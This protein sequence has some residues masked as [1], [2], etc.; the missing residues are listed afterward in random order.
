MR[1]MSFVQPQGFEILWLVDDIFFL[2]LPFCLYVCV[3]MYVQRV[4]GKRAK[5]KV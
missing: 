3:C 5:G 4:R 1:W 2:L